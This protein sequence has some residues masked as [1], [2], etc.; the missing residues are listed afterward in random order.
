M[1]RRR[2]TVFGESLINNERAFM[3]YVDRLTEMSISSFE[4]ENVPDTIDTR[5]LELVLFGKGGI[6][7]FEDEVL[8]HLCLPYTSNG[9]LDVYK[10]PLYRRAMASNG[11]QKECTAADSVII[12]NN[13]LREPSLDIVR[14]YAY[15]LWNLDRIID[16]NANAQKTP[17]LLQG[18]KE[19]RLTLLNLYKEFDGNAPVVHG[20]KN[21]DL[22][23]FKV[24]KTDAPYVSDKIY[25]LKVK[26]WNE[27]LTY[28]GISNVQ[29]QKRERLISDEVN[30]SQGG[31]IASRWSRLH[32]RE[33][34]CE[35]INKMFGLNMSVHFREDDSSSSE[36][37]LPSDILTGGEDNV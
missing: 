19:Q 20:T 6:L 27:A 3:H 16:V 30:R 26:I 35:K 14:E 10:N 13:L 18:P 9:R 36:Q 28:L 8:G 4:W 29:Y 12:Y 5:Y 25:D 33:M 22:S 7:F 21:L 37:P 17:I 34:A 24:L 1:A 11:Y 23:G 15:K 31:T 2:K 32:A